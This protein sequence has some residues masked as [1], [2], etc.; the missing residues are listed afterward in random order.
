MIKD[1]FVLND[2][3]LKIVDYKTKDKTHIL[4]GLPRTSTKEVFSLKDKNNH[5]LYVSATEIFDYKCSLK[6]VF[7][8]YD[9]I[10]HTNIY[11][12]ILVEEKN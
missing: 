5:F 6:N 9:K 2:I 4:K 7:F 1:I 8:E 12:I 3:C 10:Y 11:T